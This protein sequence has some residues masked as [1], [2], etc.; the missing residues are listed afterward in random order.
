MRQE[1]LLNNVMVLN[2]YKEQLD[3]LDPL[4]LLMNLWVKVISI[5][6]DSL[7]LFLELHGATYYIT[8]HL[9]S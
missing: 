1:L 3:K 2:I 7:I 9:A 8:L 4:L 6:R 5:I